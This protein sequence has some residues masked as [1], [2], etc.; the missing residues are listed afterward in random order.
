VR[1]RCILPWTVETAILDTASAT[2]V[3]TIRDDVTA[4]G[5]VIYPVEDAAST[6]W[7]AIHDDGLHHIVGAQGRRPPSP[8]A[9]V[10]RGLSRGRARHLGAT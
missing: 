7:Q 10:V 5:Q 9:H 6:I 3:T 2:S 1:V 8:S 4:T